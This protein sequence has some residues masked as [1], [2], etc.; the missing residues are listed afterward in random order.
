MKTERER[1]CNW[2]FAGYDENLGGTIGDYGECL[3]CETG[4]RS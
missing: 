3:T 1:K 2:L 4:V